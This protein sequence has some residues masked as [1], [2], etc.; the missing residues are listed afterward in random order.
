MHKDYLAERAV[1]LA[2]GFN[3]QLIDDQNDA[4]HTTIDQILEDAGKILKFMQQSGPDA[5]NE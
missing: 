2:L 5:D 1:E 4:A 3:R